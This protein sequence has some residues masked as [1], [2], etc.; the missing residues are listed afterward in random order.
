MIFCILLLALGGCG[1]P[2][3]PEV[4]QDVHLKKVEKEKRPHIS[5]VCLKDNQAL[6]EEDQDDSVVTMYLT[7][8]RGNQA[9]HTD[10][11][12]EE[13]N[14]YS[15][16]YYEEKNIPRYGVEA[17]L[18]V[19]NE[20]GPLYGKFG[21][22]HHVPNATVNVRGASSSQSSQKSYKV[23]IKKGM[24][25]W[26]RQKTINLNKHVYDSTRMR[27]KLAYDLIEEIP[28]MIGLR[29]QFVHLYVK[30]ETQGQTDAKFVDYGLFTQVEQPNRRFLKN[31]GL[32]S[33]G[34]LYKANFFEFLPYEDAIRLEIDPQ[35]DLKKFE[36]I[37]EIKG[38]RDHTKLIEMLRELNDYERP[39]EAVFEKY[40]DEENYF[41]WLAFQILMGNEDTQSRNFMLY[42][43]LNSPK[44]YFISWDADSVLSILEREEKYPNFD[45]GHE[46]GISNYWGSVLHK[47]V[48]AVP[49]YREKLN[50][51]II[52][53]KAEITAEKI[54]RLLNVYR[55]VVER[56]IFNMPDFMHLP[57]TRELWPD[58]V[59]ELTG[60]LE[61]N[62]DYYFDSLDEPMPFFL[63]VPKQR[64]NQLYFAWDPAYDFD[65]EN[66]QYRL[67]ISKTFLFTEHLV[68]KTLFNAMEY[69][70]PMLP[71]G[72]Y[73]YRVTATNESGFSQKAFDY[74]VSKY[75]K[76]YGMK[77]FYVDNEGQVIEGEAVA[78]EDKAEEDEADGL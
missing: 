27:N 23:S 1:E 5:E 45:P 17:I 66:I 8:R 36:Q 10:H 37:L 31:H 54:Q 41:T 14:R 62:A 70:M 48:L 65:A 64:D 68:D 3:K 77:C 57:V 53:M 76:H 73:F 28:H 51:K 52:Q 19:G 44:W 35:F 26:R 16:Y 18:Q 58:L 60:N 7:V 49:M 50:Q 63:G 30:D 67:E 40:F 74:Y 71:P 29:T 6:Y 46:K 69:H 21:Y 38:D 25:S 42:S 72:Q 11:S 20:E 22:H 39:I 12:W 43:P 9:E 59:T 78:P 33:N 75:Q 15:V 24:G 55:P 34:Q 32:N 61:M 13:V 56:Y 2:S 47:R 4:I